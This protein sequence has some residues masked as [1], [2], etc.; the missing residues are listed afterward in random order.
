ME[1][2]G[3]LLAL[4]NQADERVRSRG[5]WCFPELVLMCREGEETLLQPTAL[6]T[7]PQPP[8]SGAKSFHISFPAWDSCSK[9]GNASG[10]S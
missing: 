2:P 10:A 1:V 9:G 3:C 6:V 7:V 8:A 5:C 4:G